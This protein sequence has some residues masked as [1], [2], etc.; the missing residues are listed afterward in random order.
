MLSMSFATS[1]VA[2]TAAI[3]VYMLFSSAFIPLLDSINL[4]L[5]G[6][7]RDR[8]GRQ[9]MWGSIGFIIGSWLYGFVLQQT[10][11]H[12]LFYGSVAGLLLMLPGLAVLR[13]NRPATVQTAAWSGF[14]HFIRLPRWL[15]FALC[16]IMIGIVNNAM[17]NYLGIYIKE[18]QG[19]ATLIGTSAA[20]GALTE[21]PVMFFSSYLLRRLGSR[22]LIAIGFAFFAVRMLLYGL[23]PAPEW[24]LAIALFHGFTFA[25]Y[26]VGSVSYASELAPDNLRATAQ[27]MLM[28]LVGLAGVIGSP[29]NGGLYDWLGTAQL[30]LVNGGLAV[31][32]LVILELGRKKQ[33]KKLIY[34]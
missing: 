24:V 6:G 26:W 1:L 8:Y 20:L 22:G 10:G 30:F 33:P 23:L 3:A 4:G 25:P 19:S 12:A 16:L 21:L 7:N 9:R 17:T 5:L 28:F 27:G 31:A 15:L 18:L 11:L 32:A 29:I 34:R 13:V 2:I 14:I